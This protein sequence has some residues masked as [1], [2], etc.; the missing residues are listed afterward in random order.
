MQAIG[1]VPWVRRTADAK[2]VSD[3]QSVVV[4]GE[5]D[6]TLLL[7]F[8]VRD[9][10]AWPLSEADDALL[11]GMLRAIGMSKAT[12]CSCAI[13]QDASMQGKSGL[14]SAGLPSAL[15]TL[16]QTPRKRFLYFG[17]EAIA[18]DVIDPM[19]MTQASNDGEIDGWRLPSLAMLRETPQRKRQAW[20][21][22]KK[23][24]SA[25]MAAPLKAAPLDHN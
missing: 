14:P 8:D 2:A 13:L 4:S 19:P 9:G 7:I 16:C 24:R 12:V 15:K 5:T 11:D 23:L 1:L 25:L 21:T 6:S 22:L 17:G 10:G 3:D 20:I 18:A